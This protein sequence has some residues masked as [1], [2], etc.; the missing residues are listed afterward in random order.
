ML[1]YDH[2][3]TAIIITNIEKNLPLLA[4]SAYSS[5]LPMFFLKISSRSHHKV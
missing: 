1:H 3:H 2:R 4:W 5:H